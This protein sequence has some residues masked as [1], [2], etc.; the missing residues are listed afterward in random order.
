MVGEQSY[1]H[2]TKASAPNGVHSYSHHT[3]ARY[4]HILYIG[5]RH[6]CNGEC[7]H[8]NRHSKSPATP[9]A[10]K[11]NHEESISTMA[12]LLLSWTNKTAIKSQHR[13]PRSI[14]SPLIWSDISLLKI[15][16]KTKVTK[17]KQEQI[18]QMGCGLRLIPHPWRW[19]C[20][21]VCLSRHTGCYCW[22][23]SFRHDDR[24]H[25]LRESWRMKWSND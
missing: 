8:I 6:H 16:K 18:I 21:G 2:D 20:W 12:Q 14:H 17:T 24:P 22:S 1:Q 11:K 3:M 4:H 15:N 5:R 25:S 10:K 9:R 23:S 13:L 19:W 7:R